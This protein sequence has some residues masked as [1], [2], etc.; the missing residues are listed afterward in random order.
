MTPYGLPTSREELTLWLLDEKFDSYLYWGHVAYW[1]D[2]MQVSD[3][4]IACYMH[5]NLHEQA[6]S[7][8]ISERKV[9]SFGT[10]GYKYG[11]SDARRSAVMHYLHNQLNPKN[12]HNFDIK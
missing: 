10:L 2:I 7:V 12:I 1:Q 9:L 5:M 11:I 3:T 6:M 4:D 8:F